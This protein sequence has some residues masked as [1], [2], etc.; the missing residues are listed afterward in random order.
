MKA[1]QEDWEKI[2]RESDWG[3]YPSEA[4]IRFVARNYYKM[5]C[6]STIK[7]LDFG[8][9]AGANTWYLAREGFDVWAFDGSRSAVRKA[10][11]YLVTEGYKNVHFD[12]MDGSSLVYEGNYFNCVI[13]NVCV[14]ANTKECIVQMYREIYRVLKEGGLLFTSV[15]GTGTDGYG[16]GEHIEERTYREIRIG[17]L[18]GRA[19]AHF[20]TK[21]ELKNTLYMTGFKKISIDEMYYTDNGIKVEMLIARAEK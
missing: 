7:I 2:H 19:I 20:F 15:F 14:Y 4:V 17:V 13:D 11:E 8:C 6:R 12:V 10:K 16:N 9:G 3:R 18:Q 21:E 5:S 1:F